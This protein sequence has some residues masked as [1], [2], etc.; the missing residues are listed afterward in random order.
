MSE[1]QQLLKDLDGQVPQPLAR[2]TETSKGI[3]SELHDSL[4][5][6][7]RG[8]DQT[9]VPDYG[10]RAGLSRMDTPGERAAYLDKY[11]GGR[12]GWTQDKYGSYGHR[13]SQS[14]PKLTRARAARRA[15]P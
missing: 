8:F 1:L 4:T 11:T 5:R 14:L 12:R 13:S 15:P 7:D 6:T 9:G 3:L 10:L 2:A